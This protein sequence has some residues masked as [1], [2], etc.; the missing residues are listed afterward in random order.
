[1]MADF[2]L[3]FE[4]TESVLGLSGD[5]IDFAKIA[6]GTARLYSRPYLAKKL[7][8]YKRHAVRPLSAAN[9]QSTC[10]PRR[11]GRR[12]HASSARL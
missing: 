10:L 11:V 12:C 5:F 2:G 9:S 3:T 1:M 8:L 6:V 4:H 7:E